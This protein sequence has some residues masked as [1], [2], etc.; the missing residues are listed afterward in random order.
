LRGIS[1]TKTRDEEEDE[2]RT[3]FSD[4][5][6]EGGERAFAEKRFRALNP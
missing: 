4:T 2:T 3:E 6:S 5:F 1:R